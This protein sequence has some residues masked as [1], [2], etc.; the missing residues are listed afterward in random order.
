MTQTNR[1]RN[2][3]LL[4]YVALPMLF[5]TVVLLGGLRVGAEDRTFI[6]VAPPLVTLVL[7]IL[8]MLL[9]V[10]GRLI[11]LHQWVSSELP[12][13]TNIVHIWML[14]TLFFCVGPGFQFC[15]ARAW[16]ASLVVFVLLSVDAL[17][18]SVFLV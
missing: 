18:Q 5:L 12:P 17:E 1:S 16:L 6:F 14:I 10:R 9:L 15:P 3:A 7:A 11:R 4:D 2:R 13:L 8:L